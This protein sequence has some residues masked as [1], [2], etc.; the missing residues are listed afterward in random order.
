MA[1]FKVKF[2]HFLYFLWNIFFFL[3]KSSFELEKVGGKIRQENGKYNVWITGPIETAY[4]P[5]KI[6]TFNKTRY[7]LDGEPG[8]I[9]KWLTSDTIKEKF[10]CGFPENWTDIVV[11]E[12]KKR[13][14][15]RTPHKVR[16]QTPVEEM[17]N[18]DL[19]PIAGKLVEIIHRVTPDGYERTHFVYRFYLISSSFF[20]IL[21]DR[22]H[23]N[24]F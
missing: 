13:L 21:T 9:E 22:P 10:R 1:G 12:G 3:L 6:E 24:W 19:E 5:T 15:R 18:C 17:H 14:T 8:R 16:P 4:G 7:I 11:A 23:F 2:K 20:I